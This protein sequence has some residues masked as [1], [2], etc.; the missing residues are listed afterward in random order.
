MGIKITSLD[1]WI[2]HKITGNYSGVLTRRQIEDYQLARLQ[3]TL[4][5][6]TRKSRFYPRLYSG[7]DCNISSFQDM[8]KLPFTTSED[9]KANPHDFLC[10]S[11]NDINRIVTLQSS[12]T[13][14]NPKRLFFTK[15]DQELTIDFF[16]H[17]MLTLTKPGDRVL[18]LLPGE[19]PG[20]VGDLLCLGLERANVTGIAHGLVSNP[21]A[22]LEQIIRENINVLVG[23]PTQVLALARFKNS[24]KSTVPL[25]LK[26]VLLSTDYVPKAIVQELERTWG[27]KVFNHYG[28]T[29]MGLGGGLECEGF[30]GYHLR[31]ADFYFEIIDSRSGL[32]VL[33]GQTGEIVITTL[34]RSA[35]PLI[36]YRTGDMSRFLPG[37][38]MCNTVL[39]RLELLKSRDRV[40]LT[41]TD[42]LTMSDFDEV[43]F[44]LSNVLDFEVTLTA[45]IEKKEN[46]LQ[47][48]V[49]LKGAVSTKVQRN[50][51]QA[52]D[53]IP[54]VRDASHNGSLRVVFNFIS[55]SEVISRKSTAKRQILDKREN[56]KSNDGNSKI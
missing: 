35:M 38:C 14:G 30:C 34:T 20:S 15:A 3:E 16:H 25:N 22:T 53:K 39:K 42:Y 48:D 40:Y 33:D 5:W 51:Q 43:L 23:I 7:L 24:K 12:G 10:V 44:G 27:C 28:M 13:T 55:G 52:V 47:I 19:I 18:I 45:G 37:P 41:Q 1:P 29:E 4:N 46:Q 50:V 32:P 17:G 54:F 2:K 31:E 6:V 49:L 21:E 9:L 36:R 26:N 56:V 11:Q 8:L